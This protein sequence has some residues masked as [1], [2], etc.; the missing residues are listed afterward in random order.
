M[1]ASS[2]LGQPKTKKLGW[3]K[4]RLSRYIRAEGALPLSITVIAR[5]IIW[6]AIGFAMF[7]LQELIPKYKYVCFEFFNDVIVALLLNECFRNI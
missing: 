7:V 4:N 5:L 1:G 3:G 2:D 6:G